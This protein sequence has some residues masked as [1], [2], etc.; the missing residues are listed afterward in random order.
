MNESAE[1]DRHLR[2]AI[3]LARRGLDTVSP[4]PAVGAVV[5][6]YGRVVGEAWHRRAGAPHAEPAALEAAGELAAGA[7]LFV[8]L[9][10]CCHRGRT[11]SCADAVIEAGVSRVVACIED[12]NPLVGGKGFAKLRSAGIEVDV[13]RLAARAE[14]L[15]EVYL[16]CVRR[17]TPFVHA[18]AG[19]SLDGRIATAAGESRW[20]TSESARRYSQRLRRRYDAIL[21]GVG[22]LI[23]DDPLL[24]AR[25][26]GGGAIHRIVV[27]SRL[28]TPADAKIFSAAATGD[29][30]I[31]TTEHADK[32]RAGELRSRGADVVVCGARDEKVDPEQL[33][34]ILFQRGITGVVVEGGGE[35]IAAFLGAGLVNTVTFVYAPKIIGGHRAV[36]A[37]GGREL[38]R[39]G[40]AMRLRDLRSFRL[41]PDIAIEGYCVR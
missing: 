16:H 24:T 10:P 5:V 2:R 37:V 40:D 15:N 1:Y 7:T 18:K 34:G 25:V 36:P 38:E 8:N 26:K 29:I 22:T 30:I 35:T 39:L 21:V 4:N 41:G 20:I 6:R 27:D 23:A 11:P 31:A 28:R 12:P 19:L 13:G 3:T 17:R 9:E 14:R 32:G 33:L